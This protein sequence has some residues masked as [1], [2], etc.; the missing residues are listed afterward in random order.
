M[1]PGLMTEPRQDILT[2]AP[3]PEDLRNAIV[4]S[5]FG[6]NRE[7]K[8][9]GFS[10]PKMGAWLLR[11]APAAR[12]AGKKLYAYH[13]GRWQADG[14]E[15]Y[16][17]V[18][19]DILG[20]RWKSVYAQE[21]LN[22]ISIKAVDLDETPPRDMI[23]V[24]NGIIEVDPDGSSLSHGPASEYPLSPVCLP[25]EFDAGAECPLFMSFIN[26][27]LSPDLATL[28]QEIAG[29]LLTP[30]NSQQKCFMF[31]GPGG[32]GKST[33]ISIIGAL[34]GQANTRAYVLQQLSP[35]Y[36]FNT[37]NL[38]GK[39]AN[40]AADISPDELSSSSTLKAITGGDDIEGEHKG[41]HGFTFKPFVRMLF[42]ANKFPAIANPDQA[43]FQRWIVVPFEG[44]FRGAAEEVIGL[45][46]KV[47]E[48]ELPG[49]LNWALEGLLRLRRQG[50]FTESSATRA[51]LAAF[52]L[53]ADTIE[54]FLA[55]CDTL[56]AP[57][58]WVRTAEMY[59]AYGAW[60][61]SAGVKHPLPKM[62]FLERVDGVL[63]PRIKHSG[64]PSW[65]IR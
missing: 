60:C 3:T 59:Q 21:S 20:D 50:R 18:M 58:K 13:D 4:N 41:K 33:W 38:Y 26:S 42:S 15:Y 8:P 39:L 47:I 48:Q 2:A 29:Y 65:Q 51:S 52:K 53:K 24:L 27:A 1:E 14:E 12:D 16:G 44:S 10:A 9:T 57:G 55:D 17:R 37:A 7:G 64:Y 43:L 35:E 32:N 19:V 49:V 25:V 36:R 54:Q 40:M 63:G 23:R 61:D 11:Q 30:D 56:P 34:I 6:V 5:F 31:Q 28:T 62:A 46:T 22:W 45:S